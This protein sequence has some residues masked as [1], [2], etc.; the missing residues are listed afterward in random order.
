VPVYR[1]LRL[2]CSPRT[3]QQDVTVAVMHDVESP[4][5]RQVDAKVIE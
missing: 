2:V 3:T 4:G 1:V 5:R